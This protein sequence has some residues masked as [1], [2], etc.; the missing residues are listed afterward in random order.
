MYHVPSEKSL[1][2]EV[3]DFWN[4]KRLTV[5]QPRTLCF[6]REYLSIHYI[7]GLCSVIF[8]LEVIW[9]HLRSRVS[10][11]SGNKVKDYIIVL[12]LSALFTEYKYLEQSVLRR[13]RNLQVHSK[14]TI[15]WHFW[16]FGNNNI[17]WIQKIWINSSVLN[18]DWRNIF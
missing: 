11:Y 9:G 15:L 12:T 10:E 1:K 4:Q 6:Q 7:W 14:S 5:G 8:W 17:I 18:F 13:T 16:C 3:W 2:Y